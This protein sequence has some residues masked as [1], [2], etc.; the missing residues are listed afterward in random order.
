MLLLCFKTKIEMYALL[1]LTV[2]HIEACL[3]NYPLQ[4]VSPCPFSLEIKTNSAF[5]SLG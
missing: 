5:L 4:R 2:W 3:L 1:P